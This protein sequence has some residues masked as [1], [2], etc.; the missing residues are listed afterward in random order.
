GMENIIAHVEN[1]KKF[2]VPPIVALNRFITDTDAEIETF[3]RTIES[4]GVPVAVADPWGKGGEGVLEVADAVLD[5]IAK[6][7]ADFRPLYELDQPLTAKIETVAREIYGADGVDYLPAAKREL[8]RLEQLCLGNLQICMAKTQ[9]S[10]SNDPTRLAR[11]R[12]YRITLHKVRHSS[13]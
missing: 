5:T 12:R 13:S 9:Y 8:D 11:S 10:F 7:E 3:V 2:G 1:V 4:M 6:G